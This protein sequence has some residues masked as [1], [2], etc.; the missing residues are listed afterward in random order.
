M[1]MNFNF[2]TT[3][4]KAIN[5][6]TNWFSFEIKDWAWCPVRVNNNDREF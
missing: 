2:F 3:V 5:L 4:K 6:F 1:N